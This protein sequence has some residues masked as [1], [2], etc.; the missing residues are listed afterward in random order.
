MLSSR[1]SSSAWHLFQ[2]CYI[3]VRQMIQREIV[4]SKER[5]LFLGWKSHILLDTV[6]ENKNK[7]LNL[8][9]NMHK[10]F[11]LS[12]SYIWLLI[13]Y[14]T[15]FILSFLRTVSVLISPKFYE[16]NALYAEFMRCWGN[17][18]KSCWHC[19]LV[20]FVVCWQ[21]DSLI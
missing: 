4:T 14:S 16:A 9:Q 7:R 17:A 18:E 21:Y 8:M 15:I 13:F 2:F 10:V 1:K 6:E 3:L 19:S 5:K 20:I 12:F 11:A